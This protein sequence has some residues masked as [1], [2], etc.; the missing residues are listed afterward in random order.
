M[1]MRTA[2]PLLVRHVCVAL[3]LCAATTG[4]AHAAA[5]RDAVESRTAEADGVKLHYLTA[6]QGPAVILLHGTARR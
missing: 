1:G 2:S 6:G 3:A 5:P 4:T